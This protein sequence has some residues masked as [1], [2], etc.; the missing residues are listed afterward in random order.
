MHFSLRIGEVTTIMDPATGKHVT[1]IVTA[2][3]DGRVTIKVM[4]PPE[5]DV[6]KVREPQPPITLHCATPS[7]ACP[8]FFRLRSA[9]MGNP[10]RIATEAA[11]AHHHATNAYKPLSA[12]PPC[13]P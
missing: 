12:R 8:G 5:V 3:E 11:A 13:A 6:G 9:R 10:L 7:R 2:I 4:A 1:V